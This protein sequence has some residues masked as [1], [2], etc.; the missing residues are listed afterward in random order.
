MAGRTVRQ[1][2]HDVLLALVEPA[3]VALV[4]AGTVLPA[5]Q[6]DPPED[7]AVDVEGRAA[8]KELGGMPPR[9]IA[10]QEADR[11]DRLR[12]L[13]EWL[14]RAATRKSA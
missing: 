1:E 4:G 6:A 10:K 8:I 5:Q 2:A 12:H 3:L 13:R 11:R 9:D 14:A 7:E